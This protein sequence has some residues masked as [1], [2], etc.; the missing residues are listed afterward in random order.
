MNASYDQM[1]MAIRAQFDKVPY[2]GRQVWEP[3]SEAQ[4]KTLLLLMHEGMEDQ[5]R[6]MRLAVVGE[7]LGYP[8][9]SFKTLHRWEASILLDVLTEP[10]QVWE[11]SQ[12]GLYLIQQAESRIQA[13]DESPAIPDKADGGGA[14]DMSDLQKTVTYDWF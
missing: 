11:L 12:D 8:V 6:E 14:A 10:Q 3:C 7:L 1:K 9:D 2:M 4:R 13:G 5:S